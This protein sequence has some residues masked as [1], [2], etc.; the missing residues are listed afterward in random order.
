MKAPRTGV[1]AADVALWSF[2]AGIQPSSDVVHFL[3][4]HFDLIRPQLL[5]TFEEMCKEIPQVG[6]FP[7]EFKLE[8][9]QGGSVANQTYLTSPDLDMYLVLNSTRSLKTL[10]GDNGELQYEYGGIQVTSGMVSLIVSACAAAMEQFLNNQ[11]GLFAL[12]ATDFVSDGMTV[13]TLKESI[14]RFEGLQLEFDV[15]PVLQVIGGKFLMLSKDGTLKPTSTELAAHTIGVYSAQFPGLRE[16]MVV[17]KLVHKAGIKQQ[18][19]S[20]ALVPSCALEMVMLLLV[21]QKREG[22]AAWWRESSFTTI[23]KEAI[24]ELLKYIQSGDRLPAPNNPNDDLLMK[25][26][27]SPSEFVLYY[28]GWFQIEESNML[29]KLKACL[30]QVVSP[31]N[32]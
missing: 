27:N 4:R 22:A 15:V 8:A 28:S 26:R 10:K 7:F 11:D 30:S 16:M 21:K 20:L 13:F 18:L 9:R 14:E 3:K 23:F 19:A 12:T 6:D 5:N 31:S 1:T 24:S 2:S 32:P 25:I 17:L 29:S